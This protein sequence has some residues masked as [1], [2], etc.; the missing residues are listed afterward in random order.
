MS[1]QAVFELTDEQVKSIREWT[2]LE[3]ISYRADNL[4]C[5]YEFREYDVRVFTFRPNGDVVLE[6]REFHGEG[7]DTYTFEYKGE[8]DE[9]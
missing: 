4:V 6:E 9:N 8:T 5:W 1:R 7:W 2:T 3:E